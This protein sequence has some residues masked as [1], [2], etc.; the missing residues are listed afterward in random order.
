MLRLSSRAHVTLVLLLS[1]SLFAAPA[2][3]AAPKKNL[4]EQIKVILSRPELA[5]AHWG[6]EVV[7]LDS[8][9]VVY[10]LNPDQLFIPAS[11][12]KLFTTAAALAAAGPDY[13]FHTTVEA[14]GKT[15]P[16]GR[17]D[18]DLV[19]M[20]R[21]DPNLSGRVLPYLTCL[22]PS[23]CPCPRRCSKTWRTRWRAAV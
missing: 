13:R 7:D 19:I 12:T 3:K 6:I 5:R 23:G 10:S 21:G 22:R 16:N 11:N 9:K 8:G 14:N 17:L 2:K 4:G 20:G 18:G 1:A 15:D